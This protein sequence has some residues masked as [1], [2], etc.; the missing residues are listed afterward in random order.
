MTP[1]QVGERAEAA[2][3]AALAHVGKHVYL[4][5]GASGRCDLIFEDESGT[6]RVQVK[7][8]TVRDDVVF[9]RTC[10]NTKNEPKDYR[11]QVE[12]FGVFCHDTGS[13]YLVPVQE[14]P[15][16]AGH[17]RLR[18]TKNNQRHGI[19]WADDYRLPWSPAQLVL[20]PMSD[21]EGNSPPN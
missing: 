12:F 11:G 8:G 4:P 21:S 17:L 16:R 6:Y 13:V 7:A 3:I 14:V 15:A 9:F 10:S 2:V 18:P 19:R 1:S 5:L 20:F